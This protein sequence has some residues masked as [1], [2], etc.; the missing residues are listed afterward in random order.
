MEC[1]G[2]ATPGPGGPAGCLAGLDRAQEEEQLL[3]PAFRREWRLLLGSG[4]DPPPWRREALSAAALPS[5]FSDGAAGAAAPPAPPAPPPPPPPAPPPPAPPARSLEARMKRTRTSTF[6]V[7][8]SG[9]LDSSASIS[10]S[11]SSPSPSVPASSANTPRRATTGDGGGGDAPPRS[12]PR[13]SIARCLASENAAAK[14]LMSSGCKS[15][16]CGGCDEEGRRGG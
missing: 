8:C 6:G 13:A 16:G 11:S 5:C 3:G 4:G 10:S 2:A 7:P 9:G 12:C 1:G 14:C 15:G